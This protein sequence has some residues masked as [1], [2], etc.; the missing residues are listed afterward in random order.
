MVVISKLLPAGSWTKEPDD[1]VALDFDG[2]RKRRIKVTT[3]SGAE[4]LLDFAQ[5]PHLR[6]GDGLEA[7]DGRIIKVVAVPEPLLEVTAPEGG[8]LLELAWF[9]GNRHIPI[10]VRSTGFRLRRDPVLG[11]ML[12]GKGGHVIEIEAAFDPQSGG[13][14]HAH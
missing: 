9:L 2:R 4:F 11:R 10:D 14:D 5:T 3:L 6:E 12:V 13:S 1:T 7:G 8:R